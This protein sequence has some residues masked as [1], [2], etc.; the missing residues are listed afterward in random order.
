ML[1]RASAALAGSIGSSIRGVTGLCA[2]VWCCNLLRL[3]T[4][5]CCACDTDVQSQGQT[6]RKWTEVEQLEKELEG[7]TVREVG[8][9][10]GC[11][12]AVRLMSCRVE[13][14]DGGHAGGMEARSGV[15]SWGLRWLI[16]RAMAP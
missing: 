14:G 6:S 8:R 16:G 7:Q 9:G 12:D 5:S 11:C 10:T 13:R 3:P 4:T 1:D 2:T 15:G